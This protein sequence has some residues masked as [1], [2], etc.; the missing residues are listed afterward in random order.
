MKAILEFNL[1]E[2]QVEFKIATEAPAL[3][4]AICDFDQKLRSLYKHENQETI[5]VEDARKLLHDFLA[6]YNIDIYDE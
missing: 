4:C 5:E 3:R 2:E 1:P 6:E